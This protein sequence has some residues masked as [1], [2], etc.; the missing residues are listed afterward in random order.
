M[1]SFKFLEWLGILRWIVL[2]FWLIKTIK[3]L[4]YS[5]SYQGEPKHYH[6]QYQKYT[7]MYMELLIFHFIS[8]YFMCTCVL[9]THTH[10]HTYV[11]VCAVKR[12]CQISQK[13]SYRK[14]WAA[15]Q[16]WELNLCH[17]QGQYVLLPAETTFQILGLWI[18]RYIN[19]V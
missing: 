9:P 4:F 11:C 13:W 12:M 8:F 2:R 5:E 1:T 6:F 17:L 14:C 15:V 10:A 7:Q 3:L 16:G 18:L 19:V